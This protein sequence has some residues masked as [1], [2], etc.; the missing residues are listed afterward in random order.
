MFDPTGA[1]A[2][3]ISLSRNGPSLCFSDGVGRTRL[4]LGVPPGGARIGLADAAG[5]QRLFLG[6]SSVG[7]PTL[8]LYDGAQRRVWR[9]PGTGSPARAARRT[10]VSRGTR[11]GHRS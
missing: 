9:V 1:A 2:L 6:V 8:T 10:A 4:F 11:P 3:V 7:A 5:L